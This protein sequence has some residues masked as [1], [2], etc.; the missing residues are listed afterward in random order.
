VSGTRVASYWADA[1]T[2][3]TAP[4]GAATSQVSALVRDGTGAWSTFPGSMDA[5][6]TFKVPGVPNGPYWLRFQEV[7]ASTSDGAAV[8]LEAASGTGLDLGFDQLGRT[9]LTRTT[10]ATQVTFT[11]NMSTGTNGKSW[12]A[13]DQMQIASSNADVG[14]WLSRVA[15]NFRTNFA[16]GNSSGAPLN[17]VKTGDVTT[18]FHL[19]S[20]TDA[21]S[22][23][24]YRVARAAASLATV[25]IPGGAAATVP[26]PPAAFALVAPAPNGTVPGG[27][28]STTAFAGYR[29]LMNVPTGTGTTH[30]L[31]IGA[32]VG[33]LT[34]FSPVP[35]NAFPTLFTMSAALATTD[36]TVGSNLTYVHVLAQNGTIVA[37]W[38]EWRGVEFGGTVSYTAVGA[39]TGVSERAS[40]GRRD[41][42]TALQPMAP[43][44]SP[45]RNLAVTPTGGTTPVAAY[46]AIPGTGL[47]P[48]ISWDP[49]ALGTPTSYLVEVFRLGLSG[50]TTTKTRVAAFYTGST[51]V[52]VPPGV[53]TAGARHFVKVTARAIP[54]DPWA[55]SPLRQI[56]A[57]AWAQTLSGTITP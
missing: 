28:W 57:G 45:V 30:A 50:T 23:L 37:S 2:T 4:P 16:S 35:R 33:P 52:P 56:L 25:N 17:L 49:P 34:G 32:S 1:G 24:T 10:T 43:T 9:G 55:V 14:D 3:N 26:P 11:T 12:N 51:S 41:P 48:T 47:Q 29:T 53:L 27:T 44:L 13:A 5:A 15:P 18:M 22:T 7:P 46:T 54:S 19:Y 36:R 20:L 38:N 39:S 21:S 8:Y 31:S 6:G 40:M 42:M